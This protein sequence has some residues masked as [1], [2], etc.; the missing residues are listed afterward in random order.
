MKPTIVRTICFA[1]LFLALAAVAS[2]KG[3]RACSNAS[4]AGAWGYTETGTVVSPT[5]AVPAAA[6]GRYD[7]DSSGGFWGTQYSSAGGAV[8]T[9]TKQGTYTL[10]RDC[11]G[12][13]TL[14][15]YDSTGTILRRTSVWEIVLVE[16]AT[17]IRG[18]MTSLVLP[19]G[20]SLSP[21]MTLSAKRLFPSPGNEQKAR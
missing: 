6:V 16:N 8:S 20:F 11:T 18:I 15:V 2:A 1:T 3:H 21:I 10:N 13:L 17:E 14:S 12:T 5:G 7:F 4:L 19:N 9:D